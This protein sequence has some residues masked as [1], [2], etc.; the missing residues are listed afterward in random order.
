MYRRV[1]E[2]QPDNVCAVIL[3][4]PLCSSG[5]FFPSGSL[6][7]GSLSWSPAPPPAPGVRGGPAPPALLPWTDL[8]TTSPPKPADLDG[9]V[10]QVLSAVASTPWSDV[11]VRWGIPSAGWRWSAGPG[12]RRCQNHVAT[13][14]HK[15]T[16]PEPAREVP[17]DWQYPGTCSER[18]R[19]AN[20]K[21]SSW[22]CITLMNISH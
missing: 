14:R 15:C 4:N 21:H 7:P 12:R 18:D 13:L 8:N 10:D 11:R 6:G 2:K 22:S 20:V 17:E 19:G 3:W 9:F 5:F 1:T 16:N